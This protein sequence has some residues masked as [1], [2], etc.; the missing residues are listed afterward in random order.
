[1]PAWVWLLGF[2]ALVSCLAL[3]HRKPLRRSL[4]VLL[5]TFTFFAG[6]YS[7]RHLES[8]ERKLA[9]QLQRQLPTPA[10]IEG[11]VVSRPQT[12]PT[13]RPAD[14][15]LSKL[16]VRVTRLE[17]GG[18]SYRGSL[19]LSQYWSGEPPAYGDKII[20][21]G[22]LD[23][24]P[25]ARNPGEFDEAAVMHQQGIYLQLSCREPW[26]NQI[27]G[28]HAGNPILAVCHAAR[29]WMMTAL[30]RDLADSP[31]VIGVITGVVLGAKEN[32]SGELR[33]KFRE[34]GTLHLFAVS[35]LHV[36]MFG[37]LAW[38]AISMVI[39]Q[40]RRA[41]AILIPLLIFYALVTGLRPSVVRATVMAVVVLA[42]LLV[43]RPPNLANSLSA[44]ATL[45]LMIDPRQ[46]F[47][48]GF[49]LS[50]CVVTSIAILASPLATRLGDWWVPDPFIP[51]SLLSPLQRAW[52]AA[53]HKL[54]ALI[55]VTLA[56]WLGSLPLIYLNFHLISPIGIAAN[57]IAVALGFLVLAI[58]LLSIALS[59]LNPALGILA[60]NANWLAATA[61]LALVQAAANVPGGHFYLAK[62]DLSG[63]V[64]AKLTVFDFDD[65]AA[66]HIESGN[67]HVLVDCG[68]L[69]DAKYTLT[70]YLRSR[71]ISRL[72]AV[73]I[74]HGDANHIGGLT[75]L[76]EEFEVGCVYQPW[77]SDRSSTRKAILEDLKQREVP[78]PVL[79]AGDRLAIDQ[80]LSLNVLYPARGTR[81]F[82]TADDGCMVLQL[83]CGSTKVLLLGDAG[84]STRKELARKT[85]TQLRSHVVVTGW[86]RNDWLGLTG[87][88]QQ[89]VQPD[90]V[91]AAGNRYARQP[92][93][94][95][96]ELQSIAANGAQ[97]IDQ[98]QSGAVEIMINSTHMTAT[99]YLQKNQVRIPLN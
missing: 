83:V 70:R 74:T 57:L 14:P 90:L 52:Q 89:S 23:F 44:A 93:T 72:D 1:M 48:P 54:T 46:L 77:T 26:D 18:V 99:T 65:G 35:G 22:T 59:L 16:V 4:L 28:H 17:T 62:P 63:N 3:L 34:T 9:E 7:L 30:S 39:P 6:W 60:N 94:L 11:I 58:G 75:T 8:T 55:G 40:R 24:L 41:L 31:D 87:F 95:Q 20:A 56:A 82:R 69:S 67:R 37:V 29:E 91:V 61:L 15:K 38:V 71:G 78:A 50:F 19:R 88:L 21:T 49:Q 33:S 81:V 84:F 12:I 43:E 76:L 36:W 85:G 64:Q 73:I 10:S 2:L 45:I 66:I 27:V 96:A 5:V 51:A 92:Q 47:S 25:R 42:G 79:H 53:G 97:V 80:G 86:H 68:H 32:Q 13:K 98:Q